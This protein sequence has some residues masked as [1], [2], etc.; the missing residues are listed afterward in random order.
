MCDGAAVFLGEF[1]CGGDGLFL[2]FGWC[3][4]EGGEFAVV[5][6]GHPEGVASECFE[7]SGGGVDGGVCAVVVACLEY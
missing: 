3:V 6:L 5:E 4:G 2:V 1:S 7:D